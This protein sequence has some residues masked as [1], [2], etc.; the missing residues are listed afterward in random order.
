MRYVGIVRTGAGKTYRKS[1]DGL[2]TTASNGSHQ[3]VTFLA[4]DRALVKLEDGAATSY[5]SCL[6]R[7]IS[8]TVSFAA[9]SSNEVGGGTTKNIVR[10]VPLL[11]TPSGAWQLVLM[12]PPSTYW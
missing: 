2:T 8:Y 10:Q 6:T 7:C 11:S 3:I 5:E 9:P 4:G 1:H 12:L